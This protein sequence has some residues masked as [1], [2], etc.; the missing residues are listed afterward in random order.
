M[1]LLAANIY[2]VSDSILFLHF[3]FELDLAIFFMRDW[4]ISHYTAKAICN[5]NRILLFRFYL[6]F[7]LDTKFKAKWNMSSF[8]QSFSVCVFFLF[9]VCILFLW[10]AMK[11]P[12]DPRSVVLT[13]NTKNY[14]LLSRLYSPIDALYPKETNLFFIKVFSFDVSIILFFSI[15]MQF[16]NHRLLVAYFGKSIQNI[17][18]FHIIYYRDF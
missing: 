17:N 12:E 18:T 9:H 8:K 10:Y 14:M 2:F 5:N 7:V 3:W 1:T 16:W 6:C 4:V 15:Y 11:I 13:F